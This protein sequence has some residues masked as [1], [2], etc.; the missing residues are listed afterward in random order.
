ML[1]DTK[2]E[3]DMTSDTTTNAR[4]VDSPL[5][6]MI[7]TLQ[8]EVVELKATVEELSDSIIYLRDM[9]GDIRKQRL[10]VFDDHVTLYR[11]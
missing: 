1:K 2:K 11:R 6:E 7:H 3:L 4:E 10:E 5:A 8:D 9:I